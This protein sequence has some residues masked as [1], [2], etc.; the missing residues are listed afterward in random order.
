MV[1]FT[2]GLPGLSIGSYCVF[3]ATVEHFDRHDRLTLQAYLEERPAQEK[4]E[5]IEIFF[6]SEAARFVGEQRYMFGF[7]DEEPQPD[8][9]VMRFL[10]PVPEYMARWL[11]QYTDGIKVLQGHSLKKSLQQLQ[12]NFF[13]IGKKKTPD[14]GLL[15]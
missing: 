15:T 8:G 4:L 13:P 6:S 11:L 12:D 10:T 2:Q 9:I 3:F 5:A 7:I 1:P 14:I